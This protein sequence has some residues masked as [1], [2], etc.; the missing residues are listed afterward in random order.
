MVLVMKL[1]TFAWNVYDGQQPTESL[2]GY[3][4]S[5]AIK[6]LPGLLEFFGYW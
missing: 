3:Q 1:S 4:R 5:T 6:E 2:D